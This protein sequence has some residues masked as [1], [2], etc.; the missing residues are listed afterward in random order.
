MKKD[1]KECVE[2]WGLLIGK[3]VRLFRLFRLFR[4]L[5]TLAV[6]AWKR[7]LL[8]FC[9]HAELATGLREV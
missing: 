5:G 9:C 3:C 4:L 1:P 2:P 8:F 6:A 7:P